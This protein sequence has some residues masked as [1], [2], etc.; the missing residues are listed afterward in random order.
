VVCKNP[1]KLSKYKSN[2]NKCCFQFNIF[3][4]FIPYLLM[5]HL[6]IRHDVILQHPCQE[7]K[8][9]SGVL[10]RYIISYWIY[11]TNKIIYGNI[12]YSE[13]IRLYF[14]LILAVTFSI[15]GYMN[16]NELDNS[17][18]MVTINCLVEI[19]N[20]WY[21]ILSP[22]TQDDEVIFFIHSLI[23]IRCN[24]HMNVDW[25]ASRYWTT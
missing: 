4:K 23:A 6:L 3:K 20:I 11:I 24:C 1:S 19:I 10:E 9:L 2:D 15:I 25:I 13:G 17:Q 5:T 12:R 22:A 7:C 8:M 18:I 14:V 16:M 21:Y